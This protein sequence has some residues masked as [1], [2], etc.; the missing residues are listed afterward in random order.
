[1]KTDIESAQSVEMKNIG[2]IAENAGIDLK[3]VEYYG[4][5]K[6]KID[7]SLLK[8]SKK[9]NGKLVLAEIVSLKDNFNK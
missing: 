3:Y 9:E 1:M 7:L 4:N 8:E 5:Y 6:A 2:V